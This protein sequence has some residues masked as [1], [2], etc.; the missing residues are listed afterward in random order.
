MKFWHRYENLTP[1]VI[2]KMEDV[3]LEKTGTTSMATIGRI[4]AA[5]HP[6]EGNRERKKN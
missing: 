1:N 4:D 2:M 5:H 3:T 6:R